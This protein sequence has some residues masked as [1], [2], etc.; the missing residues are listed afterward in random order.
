MGSKTVTSPDPNPNPNPNP[1]LNQ[2]HLE[3][4]E[5]RHLVYHLGLRL[6]HGRTS[7]GER[8]GDVPGRGRWR[9]GRWRWAGHGR[10]RRGWRWARRCVQV[11]AVVEISRQQRPRPLRPPTR[12]TSLLTLRAASSLGQPRPI[13]RRVLAGQPNFD[14]ATHC[15]TREPSRLSPPHGATRLRE[16]PMNTTVFSVVVIGELAS[17]RGTSGSGSGQTDMDRNFRGVNFVTQ[18]FI[19]RPPRR[20]GGAAAQRSHRS[21]RRRRW[22][23][24]ELWPT[25]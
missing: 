19:A 10:R 11:V 17:W 7:R 4:V 5:D 9:R 14:M 22:W 16:E 21:T 12:P 24:L 3:R 18:R 1:S 6:T 23:T 13:S 15:S 25:P 20:R 2:C 8:L